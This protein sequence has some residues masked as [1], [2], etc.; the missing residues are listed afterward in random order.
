MTSPYSSRAS[1]SD[2]VPDV[3]KGTL[4]AR[5][6]GPDDEAAVPMVRGSLR[7]FVSAAV[8]FLIN[9][10]AAA[11]GDEITGVAAAAAGGQPIAPVARSI[12]RT[13]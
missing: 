8:L 5:I 12:R 9:M 6:V 11:G 7:A 3:W 10:L 1:R 4:L 2:S 13:P